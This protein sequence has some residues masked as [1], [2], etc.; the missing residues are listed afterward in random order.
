[1]Q[2]GGEQQSGRRLLG[3]EKPLELQEQ[4]LLRLGYK[5]ASR[6]SRLGLDSELKHL[7]GFHVGKTK[8]HVLLIYQFASLNSSV[9][10]I[11]KNECPR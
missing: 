8:F 10:F 6:R 4:L 2:Y 5:D 1:M 7:V 3:R 9:N 11:F